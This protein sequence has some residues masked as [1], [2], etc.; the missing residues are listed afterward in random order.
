MTSRAVDLRVGGQ[1]YR[2][3]SS[4]SAG[5]LER[6]A[7]KVD[8]KLSSLVPPGR[9]LGPNSLLLAALALAHDA[10]EQR[11]RADQIALLARSTVE[12]L[13]GQVDDALAITEGALG[14]S[15][16]GDPSDAGSNGASVPPGPSE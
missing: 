5:E 15:G 4:A 1:S 11:E 6:F 7:A 12:R 9:P 2:V 10:E 14:Q 3:V 16:D 13:L 8:E